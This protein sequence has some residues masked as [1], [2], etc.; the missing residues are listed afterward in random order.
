MRNSI[1]LITGSIFLLIQ[2][3]NSSQDQ[4]GGLQGKANK[5]QI[6]VVGKVPGRIQSLMVKVGDKVMKGDTLAIIDAPEVQAKMAQAQGAVTSARAQYEMSVRGASANQ[7]KQLQA[8]KAAL[9]EQYEYARKS[10]K[11]LESL[12]QD[13]LIPQQQYD[14][15]YAKYQGAK[16]QVLA[17]DAEI[18]GVEN[19]VRAEQQIMARGQEDRAKGALQEAEIADQERYIRA[20]QDMTIEGVT[21]QVGELALPGYTLFTGSLDQSLHFRFTLPESQLKAYSVGTEVTV[22]VPYRDT[23]LQGK[24]QKI[25]PIGA[26][27]NIASAYPDYDMQDPLYELIVL[28]ADSALELYDQSNVI[29]KAKP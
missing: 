3:C 26:Y 11:R 20:P 4:S 12:V 8:K 18:A 19:G 7:L 29:L 10:L 5:E 25:K 17:V 28:P 14:A 21:L 2:G 16:A 9:T 13:S 6:A 15:V 24:I 27:A 23:I 22:E 1:Y